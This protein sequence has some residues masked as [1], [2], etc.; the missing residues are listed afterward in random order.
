ME[1]IAR[2]RQIVPIATVQ[3]RYNVSDRKWEKVLRYC[4][5]EGLGFM[6]WSPLGGGSSL[7]DA[8]VKTAAQEQKAS[9]YQVAI[10]WLAG[11]LA[12]HA[13]DPGYV[14]GRASGGKRGRCKTEVK[15]GAD[16]GTHQQLALSW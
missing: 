15:R 16:A 1:E 3:N 5:K 6:P 12:G 13:A 7:K 2:A 10:A 11:P 4:E 8:A 9:V 14:V